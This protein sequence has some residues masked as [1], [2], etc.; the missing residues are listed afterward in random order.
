MVETLNRVILLNSVR[1]F[2]DFVLIDLVSLSNLDLHLKRLCVDVAD[3]DA[4]LGGEQDGVARAV[5]VN[6][7]VRLVTLFWG[8]ENVNINIS[9][10]YIGLNSTNNFDN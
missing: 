5:R 3:V 6:A 7:N 8:K 1:P 10:C 9:I 2:L 4:A